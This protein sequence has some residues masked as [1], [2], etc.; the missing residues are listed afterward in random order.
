MAYSQVETISDTF[1][2]LDRIDSNLSYMLDDHIKTLMYDSNTAILKN[3]I[4]IFIIAPKFLYNDGIPD[5]IIDSLYNENNFP[6]TSESPGYSVSIL[7]VL[8]S[9][10]SI[11]IITNYPI[12]YEYHYK[13]LKVVILSKLKLKIIGNK[14]T[15]M[16]KFTINESLG[17]LLAHSS[18]L[19]TFEGIY[20]LDNKRLK[21]IFR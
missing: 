8:D 13:K 4:H 9:S 1:N 10:P 16:M 11:R 6:P 14:S 17:G 7:S 5:K 15:K 18:Y 21:N 12:K 3:G 20:L 19:Y 2:V